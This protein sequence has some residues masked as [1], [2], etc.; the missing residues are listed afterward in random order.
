MKRMATFGW[1]ATASIAGL[2]VLVVAVGAL[3]PARHRAARMVVLRHSPA[4]IWAVIT[5]YPAAPQWRS[6][7]VRVERRPD[8]GGDPV[9]AEVDRHGQSIPY[10]TVDRD[11]ERRLVRKIADERLPFGGTWTFEL[12]A[13]PDGGTRVTITERG[14][15]R[16]PIFRF[17]S[18]FVIG[19]GALMERYLRSLGGKFGEAVEPAPAR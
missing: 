11:P 15:V 3:L 6:D 13:Q 10:V 9:W 1:I 14:E 19:H 12:A 5:D 8:Q 16:N 4:E 18:R 17:V 2:V 7:V